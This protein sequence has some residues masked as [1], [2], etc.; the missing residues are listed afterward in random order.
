MGKGAARSGMPT[1]SKSEIEKALY[2]FDFDY[3]KGRGKGDHDH[4]EH[5]YLPFFTLDLQEK[6]EIDANLY[7]HV[8]HA[9]AMIIEVTEHTI[10]EL[11]TKKLNKIR[12]S[13]DAVLRNKAY[14]KTMEMELKS[15]RDE[16]GRPY[17]SPAQYDKFL[18]Q[19][20][21]EYEAKRKGASSKKGVQAGEDD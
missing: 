1:Y 7:R 4:F 10:D 3:V 13:T 12:M 9:I 11:N 6:K 18:K 16:N 20:K 5:K 14:Y 21:K 8:V 15:K 2:I 19:L 17:D